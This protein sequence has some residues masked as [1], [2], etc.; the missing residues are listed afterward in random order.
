M[1]FEP[2][3]KIYNA[4]PSVEEADDILRNAGKAEILS[5]LAAVVDR[6]NACGKI[7]LRLLHKHNEVAS[8]ET[9]LEREIVADGQPGL[10]TEKSNDLSDAHPNSW[11]LVNGNAYPLEYTVGPARDTEDQFAEL[12][13][14][15]ESELAALKLNSFIGPWIPP[16]EFIEKYGQDGHLLV[17]ISDESSTTNTLTFA[18]ARDL[19]PDSFIETSWLVQPSH[20][21]AAGLTVAALCRTIYICT[22][23][24]KERRHDR[25]TKHE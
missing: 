23:Y 24:E 9:M 21:G 14:E 18:P 20:L 3:H 19:R 2:N 16:T 12:F 10:R 4:L 17:E 5:R 8:G 6:H 7:G 11:M 15:L 22:S 13:S 25:G 1:F